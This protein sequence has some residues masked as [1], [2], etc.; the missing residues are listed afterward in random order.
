M[1]TG[2]LATLLLLLLASPAQAGWKRDRA[3]A[4]AQIVWNH[5]CA[6]VDIAYET[7]PEWESW[8]AYSNGCQVRLNAKPDV[9]WLWPIYCTTMIHELGHAAGQQHSSNPRSVMYPNRGYVIVN[10][11]V[12]LGADRRCAQNGVPYLRQHGALAATH[13]SPRA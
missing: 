3:L 10:G 6:Q 9:P 7:H 8:F 13:R 12:E 4:I 11:Q 2:L 5:P 1:R